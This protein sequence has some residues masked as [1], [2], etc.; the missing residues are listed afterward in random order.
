MAAMWDCKTLRDDLTYVKTAGGVSARRSFPEL[1]QLVTIAGR[2]GVGTLSYEGFDVQLSTREPVSGDLAPVQVNL[3]DLAAA[4]KSVGTGQVTISRDDQGY[5]CVEGIEGSVAVA[6]YIGDESVTAHDLGSTEKVA[7]VSVEA[8]E[9]GVATASAAVAVSADDTLPMLCG[10]RLEAIKGERTANLVATDRFRLVSAEVAVCDPVS[11]DLGVLIPAKALG[12]FAKRTAKRDGH[13]LIEVFDNYVRLTEDRDQITIHLTE[14]EFPKWRQLLPKSGDQR[15]RTRIDA[16]DMARRLRKVKSL[17]PTITVKV[18]GDAME[19]A[20]YTR[21]E[22]RPAARFRAP[23]EHVDVDH[24]PEGTYAGYTCDYLVS[25]LGKA[26]KGKVEIH[27]GLDSAE[28][29]PLAIEWPGVQSILM[30]VRL[31]SVA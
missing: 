8:A 12:A 28:R 21:D 23:A 6:P 16:Q 10:I 15:L 26:P 24:T 18:D 4:L 27:W 7:H 11:A 20:T 29:K 1:L 2:D 5:V 3:G 25:M 9:L 30:P 31:E 13:V 14:C 19:V 17:A 22:G